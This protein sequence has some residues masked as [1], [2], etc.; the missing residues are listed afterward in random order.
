MKAERMTSPVQDP[1]SLLAQL[2]TE[3]R[4]LEARLEQLDRNVY[5]TPDEQ[6]E[7]KRIQ[8]MKLQTKDRIQQLTGRPS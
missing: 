4:A 6:F 3:H 5:L 7:R 2:R 8:K 1:G